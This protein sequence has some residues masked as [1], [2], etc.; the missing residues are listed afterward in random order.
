MGGWDCGGLVQELYHFLKLAPREDKT[1]AGLYEFF[2]N[3]SH[4]VRKMGALAFYGEERISHVAMFLDEER[5][6]EAGGGDETTTTLEAAIKK[7][8]YVR[9][10]PYDRR[11]DLRVIL[12]PER[13]PW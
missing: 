9:I 4:R 7:N 3:E 1:A 5:I 8:A 10:R 2:K 11:K 6:I 13:L 12:A